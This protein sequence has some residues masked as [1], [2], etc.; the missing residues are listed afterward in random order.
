MTNPTLTSEH[1]NRVVAFYSK[2]DRDSTLWRGTITGLITYDTAATMMDIVAYHA[3]VQRVD[4]T[5][6]AASRLNYFTLKLDTAQT[7][8]PQFRVFAQQW[9]RDNS[10]V[11][12][13]QATQYT[14]VVYDTNNDPDA[15]QR[16]LAGAGYRSVLT[17][18]SS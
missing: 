15:I 4:P 13:D 6:S 11:F 10:L 1:L 2:A 18:V 8:A 12:V 14:F 17:M 16:L 7:E 3:M 5:I 9:I